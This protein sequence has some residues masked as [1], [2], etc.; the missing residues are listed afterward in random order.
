MAFMPYDPFR[1]LEQLREEMSK[2][3]EGRAPAVPAERELS[4]A[5]TSEWIPLVDIKEEPDRFIVYMDVPGVNPKDI[6]ISMEEGVL[7]IKGQ[8]PVESEEEQAKYT[9]MERPR[10]A[11]QRRF[12]LPDTAD[13]EKISARVKNGVL[14]LVIPK[15]E[16][17]QPRKITVEAVEE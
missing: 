13:A 14:E 6:E 3:F 12:T 10:G 5:F 16:K 15:H 17:V 7:T 4:S 11:F 9:R 1:T 2:L 8:R